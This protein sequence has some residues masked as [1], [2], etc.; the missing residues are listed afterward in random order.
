[1]FNTNFL[2]SA[3]MVALIIAGGL[4]GQAQTAIWTNNTAT[5]N[6][7]TA[8]NWTNGFPDSGTTTSAS[9]TNATTVTYNAPMT[10]ASIPALTL[11]FGVAATP[12][13]VLNVSAGGFN[14]TGTTTVNGGAVINV[15]AGGVMTNGT[16]NIPTSATV[17]GV[18]VNGGVMTNGATAVSNNGSN[19]GGPMRITN[20]AVVN[21]GNV[22]IKRSGATAFSSGLTI[23]NSTVTANSVTVGSSG[24]NSFST[25]SIGGASGSTVTINGNLLVAYGSAVARAAAFNFT[26]GT[27]TVGGV[28]SLAGAANQTAAFSLTTPS[29][30]LNA[31][32]IILFSN[33]ITGATN[34]F[35]NAGKIYLGASGF[36]LTNTSGNFLNVNYNDG[37]L[38]GASADWGGN[39]TAKIPSGNFTFR[40]ADIGGTAHNIYYSGAISGAGALTKTGAGTLLLDAT[41]TYTGNTFINTGTLAVGPSGAIN[42]S[43]QVIVGS[44]TTLDVSA[45][46]SYTVPAG[47]TLAGFGVVTGNVAF[48]SAAIL[49]AG[50]NAVTGTLSFSN[51]ITES[52]GVVNHFDL[53]SNPAGPNND[54]ILVGGD[55]NV[56]GVSNILEI[57]GGGPGGSVHTLFKYFGSFIGDVTNFTII[58]PTGYL[59]N[60]TSVTPKQINFVVASTVRSATNTVWVGNASNNVWDNLNTTN[61]LNGTT[62]DYFVVGDSVTFGNA[63]QI[64]SNVTINVAVQPSA[65]TV[66]SSGDYVFDGSASIGGLGGILKTNTGKLTIRNTNNFSGGVSVKQ[67]MVSVSSLADDNSPSPLGQTGTL[68]VDGGTLEYTGPNYTW[69]RTLTLGVSAGSVSVPTGV[70]LTHSGT[71]VGA[72]PLIKND[73]GGLT[74]SGSASTYSSGTT[75]NAGTL[76]LNSATAASS[77]NII[78]NGGT[79]VLGVV[80]PANT[81]NITGEA[82]I[83][84]GNSAGNTGIKNVIGSSN[85][86]VTVNG[87]TT[88]DLTGDMTAY[89]GVI[90]LT[91]GTGNFV[92]LN[93]STGSPLA[94]WNL[95]GN[96]IDLNVRSGATAITLGGLSGVAGSTLSGRG[97]SANNGSTTMHIGANGLNTTFDGIIQNG[98]G[99]G[100][101]LTH[102]VKTGAGTLT[103]SGGNTYTGT[104]V[105]SNGVLALT[106]SGSIGSTP[107]ITINSGATIDVSGRGDTALNLASGQTLRG[108][109][110]IRGNLDATGGGTV[111]P[112]AA[113]SVIGQLTVTNVATLG[114]TIIMDLNRTNSV[115][116]NDILSAASIVLGGT[117]TVTNRGPNLVAGDR[118]VLFNGPITGTFGTVNLP[119]NLGNVTYT[120][121]NRTDIDGSIQVLTVVSVNQ[122]PTNLVTSVSG[123]TLTL[124]WPTDHIGWRLQSQ[125]NSLSTGLGSGWT[126]VDNTSTT[127]A[128]SITLDPA[129]GAV[130]YRMVYP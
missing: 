6:W 20:G 2:R 126:D 27:V 102:V 19:D 39:V 41:E 90:S 120:W 93:G 34:N 13:P 50:T 92:R 4:K 36:I 10:P 60:D 78:L 97:G 11:S 75:L 74:L 128:V 47:K 26:N 21:L 1:M 30:T 18:T 81:L 91:N 67:G 106:G 107:T 59:T 12:A 121:T 68:L 63:G 9:I 125:T 114:G 24:A 62:L 88:F 25:M 3:M 109:G 58:G 40:A 48:A 80:K 89:S 17:G 130:F 51:N 84:G 55:F 70:T 103:L 57:A 127:N 8:A 108:D 129:N 96:P 5:G 110:I 79:L 72:G 122:T 44:G 56:S 98:G 52:G 42:G 85:L 7:N 69:T 23:L 119:E 86:L 82:Q 124:S 65:T 61:W 66:N 45:A 14:V 83:V 31:S 76:T 115:L 87:G 73:L 112:G 35:S 95:V 94:T 99:G 105:V 100:S 71:I 28:V 33:A 54:L 22:T 101:A 37:G 53:S 46:T 117:L 116:T 77:G 43:L 49:N 32:G 118:F 64:N 113:V 38:L 111:S 15:V 104:T 16:L 29:T 123:N